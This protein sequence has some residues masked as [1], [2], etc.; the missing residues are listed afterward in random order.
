MNYIVEIVKDE[1]KRYGRAKREIGKLEQEISEINTELY[2]IKAMT[3]RLNP[4]HSNVPS[5]AEDRWTVLIARKERISEAYKD[6]LKLIFLMEKSLNQLKKRERKLME[7]LWTGER[8]TSMDDEAYRRNMS[9]AS[10]YRES[11]R[12]LKKIARIRWG[13]V[14]EA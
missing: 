5:S 3:L 2:D 14:H 12:I 4:S 10:L 1:L 6:D 11:D 7:E 13:G 8:Y 9:R